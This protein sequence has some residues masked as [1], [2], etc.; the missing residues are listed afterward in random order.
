M[1]NDVVVLECVHFSRGKYILLWVVRK[2]KRHTLPVVECYYYPTVSHPCVYRA[3]TLV[4]YK[5]ISLN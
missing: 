1:L 3:S 2:G 4:C 5:S